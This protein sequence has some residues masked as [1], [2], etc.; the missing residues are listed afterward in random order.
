[1]NRTN[2][3][4]ACVRAPYGQAVDLACVFN[5]NRIKC[6]CL[7]L[8]RTRRRTLTCFTYTFF[9]S[10]V[11]FH[12]FSLTHFSTHPRRHDGCPPPDIDKCFV[13]CFPRLSF[14]TFQTNALASVASFLFILYVLHCCRL[15]TYLH[16]HTCRLPTDSH[17]AHLPTY[18]LT[19]SLLTYLLTRS[20]TYFV[21]DRNLLN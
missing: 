3:T 21:T 9:L 19:H 15:P 1:M 8:N 11:L 10:Y 17:T 14:S 12:N 13:A 6:L 4:H 2:H 7:L 20:L 5:Q 18:P 16:P